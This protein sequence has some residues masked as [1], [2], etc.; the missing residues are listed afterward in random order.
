MKILITGAN[1]F[2]G[3]NLVCELKK[4]GYDELYLYDVD[5]AEDYLKEAAS[6]C[7]V[8]FHLA[9]INRPQRVEEFM[10]GNCNFTGH[11][12]ELIK[13]SGNAPIVI[14]TS[15]IQAE[16]DNPYGLSKKAG[17]E[18]LRSYDK[19]TKGTAIIYRL[20][21]VFGKWCR[22]NY[23]SAVATFCHNIAHDLPIQVNDPS[24]LMHLV[25]IDDVVRELIAAMNGNPHVKD[26]YGYV[27][28]VNDILLGRIPELLY[29]FKE[30]RETLKL[31]RFDDP[32]EKK[33]YS[34]Y[35]S[36]LEPDDFSYPL[37]MKGDERGSFTEFL[38]STEKGQVSVN[39]AHPGITKGNHW[40]STKNEKFFVVAGR[41]SIK[42][43]A[44]GSEEVI[45]Y[46]V[47]GDEHIVVDIPC[48]YT[49]S[50]TN[51]GEGDLVTI[52]WVNEPFDPNDSDTYFEAVEL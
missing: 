7:D 28:E 27:P 14:T 11:L 51:I 30:S 49:H 4:Q 3:K 1:G 5:S 35:L 17:E 37:T 31:P 44:V 25:Y 34:T 12:L 20:P 2:I 22:P 48:G 36:Y 50:I 16:L 26:G 23:N 43:R 32:F 38:R 39:V 52:M 8:V 46:I 45:E 42:F 9:G 47:S 24:V 21:N 6:K 19:D 18:L 10:E 33:L 13:A 40:H 15:S 29:F 41:A